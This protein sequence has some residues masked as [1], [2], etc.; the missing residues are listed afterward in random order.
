MLVDADVVAFV[1]TRDPKEARTFYER[2][3]AWSS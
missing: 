2:A 3:W 1:P